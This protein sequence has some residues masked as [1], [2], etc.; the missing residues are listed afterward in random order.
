[1]KTHSEVF[2]SPGEVQDGQRTAIILCKTE[3]MHLDQLTFIFLQQCYKCLLGIFPFV[4]ALT[5]FDTNCISIEEK[6]T[7][8]IKPELM[9]YILSL[10]V[11][12]IR[13]DSGIDVMKI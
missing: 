2:I 12:T 10:D 9:C 1:M 13:I 4:N 7:K 11:N 6:E 5:Y 3:V 8:Q